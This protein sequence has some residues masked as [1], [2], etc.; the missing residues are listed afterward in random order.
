MCLFFCL[1]LL[2]DITIM[3]SNALQNMALLQIPACDL[4]HDKLCTFVSKNHTKT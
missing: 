3:E 1:Q 4:H 2:Y